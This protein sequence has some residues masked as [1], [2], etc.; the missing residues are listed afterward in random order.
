MSNTA[1][2]L[3]KALQ[4]CQTLLDQ[5]DEQFWARKIKD[6]IQHYDSSKGPSPRSILSWFGGTGSF[7]DLFLSSYNG[8]LIPDGEETHLNERFR[9]HRS[10]IYELADKLAKT[11]D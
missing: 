6:A 4:D 7:N 9:Y 3:H 11:G 8:H 10:V 2:Q 1:E 5:S